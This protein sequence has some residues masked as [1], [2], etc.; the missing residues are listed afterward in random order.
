M[1][2]GEEAHGALARWAIDIKLRPQSPPADRTDYSAE[3]GSSKDN[4][5]TTN[6]E[7]FKCCISKGAKAPSSLT[8]TAARRFKDSSSFRSLITPSGTGSFSL[9][10]ML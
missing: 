8:E 10:D 2:A 7:Y 1:C 4:N 9:L 3:P 6:N 5:G